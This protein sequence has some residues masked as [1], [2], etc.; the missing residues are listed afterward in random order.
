MC[1]GAPNFI[2]GLYF[3]GIIFSKSTSFALAGNFEILAMFVQLQIMPA[4]SM[5]T[6]MR[7]FRVIGYATNIQALCR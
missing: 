2:G 6:A 3:R 4:N 1:F 7:D 5:D